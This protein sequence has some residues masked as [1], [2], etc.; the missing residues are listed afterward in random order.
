MSNI[1]YLPD[2]FARTPDGRLWRRH[3]WDGPNFGYRTP[4]SHEETTRM[5]CKHDFY[6]VDVDTK[7]IKS[8][9]TLLTL[10][11]QSNDEASK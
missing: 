4:V 2:G 10:S 8:P 5:G 6:L 3:K 7:K 9:W 1:E 11:E